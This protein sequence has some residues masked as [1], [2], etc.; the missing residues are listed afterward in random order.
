MC[1]PNQAEQVAQVGLTL[2]K[3]P[4]IRILSGLNSLTSRHTVLAFVDWHEEFLE[5]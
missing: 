3:S 1:D 4:G 5:T 2:L